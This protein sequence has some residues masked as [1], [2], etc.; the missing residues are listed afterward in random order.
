MSDITH[1]YPEPRQNGSESVVDGHGLRYQ[2]LPGHVC[3]SESCHT[4]ATPHRESECYQPTDRYLLV[5]TGRI[6][7]DMS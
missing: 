1:S 2:S 6:D 7:M 5:V 3:S 4:W